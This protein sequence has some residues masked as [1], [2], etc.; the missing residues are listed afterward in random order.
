MDG[1][2]WAKAITSL[3]GPKLKL[4]CLLLVYVVTIKFKLGSITYEKETNCGCSP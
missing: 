2:K 4:N 3:I 1:L